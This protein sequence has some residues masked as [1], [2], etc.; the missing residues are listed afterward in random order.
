MNAISTYVVY[1]LLLAASVVL[2]YLPIPGLL[3]GLII[4]IGVGVL[5]DSWYIYLVRQA[6]MRNQKMNPGNI[7]LVVLICIHIIVVGIMF[8]VQNYFEPEAV[9]VLSDVY[10]DA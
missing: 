5:S 9:E 6:Y 4:N 10:V 2:S 1:A 7:P 8:Q 3:F